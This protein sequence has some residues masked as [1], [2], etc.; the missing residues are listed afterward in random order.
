MPVNEI[1]LNKNP[2]IFL[3]CQDP[4]S[5]LYYFQLF[6]LHGFQGVSHT[7]DKGLGRGPGDGGGGKVMTFLIK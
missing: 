5:G 2:C 3:E 4:I 6:I 1:A 7:Y